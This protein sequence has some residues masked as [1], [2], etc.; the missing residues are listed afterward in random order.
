[1]L[2]LGVVTSTCC[3]YEVSFVVFPVSTVGAV[4]SL[5]ML[6]RRL[7]TGLGPPRCFSF[8]SEVVNWGN[9]S[10]ICRAAAFAFRFS[11]RFSFP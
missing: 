8:F 7:M 2:Y 6:F 3:C 4:G 10:T 11:L 9:G 5:S 1:M